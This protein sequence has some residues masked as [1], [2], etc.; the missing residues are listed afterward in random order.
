[1]ISKQA[2]DE[3]RVLVVTADPEYAEEVG[4]QLRG[5]DGFELAVV[6]SVGAAVD[7]L[8][9]DPPADCV[10]CDDALP[11]TDGVVFLQTVRARFP[12]V[13]F[14]LVTGG[15]DGDV[16]RRAIQAGVTE[17]LDKNDHQWGRFATLIEEAIRQSAVR[18][19][20]V[21]TAAKA[22][23]VLDAAHDAI[24]IVR[25]GRYEYVNRAGA[26]L[27]GAAAAGDVVGR[28]LVDTVDIEEGTITA[29]DVASVELGTRTLGPVE[30]EAT[31]LDGSR[32]PVE[33]TATRMELDGDPG[34]VVVIRDVS[35]RKEREEALAVAYRAM[36]ATPVGVTLADASEEDEPVRYTNDAFT[37]LTGYP[38][39]EVLGR[40]CRFL[41]GEDTDPEPVAEMRRA[42][43]AEEPVTVELRNYRRDGTEFW[44]RVTI[45][46]VEN[47][48]GAVTHYVGFQE[49]VTE[50]KEREQRL[51]EYE[52][53][54]EGSNDLIAAI[55]REHRYLFA[56]ERYCEYHGVDPDDITGSTLEEVLGPGV[57]SSIEPHVDRVLD[58][59][60]VAYR[61]TRPREHRS[62]RTFDVRYYPLENGSES[63]VGAVATLRDVTEQ[64]AR[65]RQLAVFDRVLRHNLRNAMDVMIGYAEQL[66]ADSRGQQ[67]DRALE[68]VETGRELIELTDQEHRIVKFLSEP[69]DAQPLELTGIVER[70]VESVRERYPEAEVELTFQDPI[71]VRM[72]PRIRRAVAELVK[73][74]IEHGEQDTP[75]VEVTLK[76]G[77]DTVTITV[78]DNGPGI[79]EPE[80]AILTGGEELDQL[81]HGTGLDLWLVNWIVER[82]DGSLAFE[83]NEPRGSVVRIT[84][85]RTLPDDSTGTVTSIPRSHGSSG[86]DL[87]DDP[88][89]SG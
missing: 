84:L 40:N 25:E 47:D 80:L 85:P 76:A 33:I 22:K 87:A 9:G 64:K 62:D 61:M 48:E 11:D 46:P 41:Q 14:F 42:I 35:D 7:H 15:G 5:S 29:E 53:A 63:V 38:E 1:M 8:T 50:A 10:V 39:S 27:F 71:D 2:A 58:G 52:R 67:R 3:P 24:A 78:A 31:G 73:N 23:Q 28:S 54:V 83:E 30:G 81:Y 16:A 20:L 72:I 79:P 56:N 13:P 66:A 57:W 45:A 69:R 86:G 44:N 51:R 18:R 68:I 82:C 32:T 74:G 21:D 60:T 75:V 49:D 36:D 6:E 4:S 17:C 77:D 88:N 43:D 12:T 34:V 19:D 37:E 70:A 55:D 26:D 59:E 89:S 65:E